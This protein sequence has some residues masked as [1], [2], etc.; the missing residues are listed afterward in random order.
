MNYPKPHNLT[1]LTS[2]PAD[3]ICVPGYTPKKLEFETGSVRI[4]KYPPHV[5][6]LGKGFT[7]HNGNLI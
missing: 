7:D 6:V 2:I 4:P 3:Y 1:D 5:Y